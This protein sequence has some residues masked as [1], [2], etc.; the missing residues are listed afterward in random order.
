MLRVKVA[1]G[2]E[3][4]E[5]LQNTANLKASQKLKHV[6]IF[7]DLT[8]KQRQEQRKFRTTRRCVPKGDKTSPPVSGANATAI[9]PSVKQSRALTNAALTG[10]CANF[11]S[12]ST[13]SRGRT[14]SKF[15]SRHSADRTGLSHTSSCHICHVNLN[16][17]SNKVSHVRSALSDHRINFL[18][19]SETWLST[20]IGVS[21]I[22]I[23]L[24]VT[25]S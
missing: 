2:D 12:P 11:D 23:G 22:N 4:M 3:R 24:S 16:N 8:F 20:S 9:S 18:R 25:Q 7:R 15:I 21:S 10:T 17:L 14:A 1:N 13:Y 19:V 6:Y 5:L